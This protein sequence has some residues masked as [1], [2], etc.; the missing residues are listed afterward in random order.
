[1]SKSG[2]QPLKS[3][4]PSV[5]SPLKITKIRDFF[6]RITEFA[7]HKL[8]LTISE[9]IDGTNNHSQIKNTQRKSNKEAVTKKDDSESPQP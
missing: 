5:R 8:G 9:D 7:P 3:I 6:H 4:K 2:F 1:M